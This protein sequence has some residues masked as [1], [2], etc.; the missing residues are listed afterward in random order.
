M[1]DKY[2]I[3][4]D[5][6][7]DNSVTSKSL[8]RA[9]QYAETFLSEYPEGTEIV[10]FC[11][12]AI[13][14]KSVTWTNGSTRLRKVVKHTSKSES[15]TQA[16]GTSGITRKRWNVTED[17]KLLRMR[18]EG[19]DYEIIADALDRTVK[20]VQNRYCRLQKHGH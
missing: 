15:P 4:P 3:V 7:F 20:S 12:K 16:N 10:I 5:Q 11:V 13:A 6:D 8:D 17:A 2:L 1:C 14:K 9:K 19:V 18:H